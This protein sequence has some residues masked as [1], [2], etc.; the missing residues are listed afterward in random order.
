MGT[1][2]SPGTATG[3][4]AGCAGCTAT[5][6]RSFVGATGASGRASAAL[7]ASKAGKYNTAPEGSNEKE[8]GFTHRFGSG[9][10]GQEKAHSTHRLR[11]PSLLGVVLFIPLGVRT[12]SGYTLFTLRGGSGGGKSALG[13]LVAICHGG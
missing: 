2:R 8:D 10:A 5:A 9:T 12:H 13:P 1:A 4:A 7:S 3:G 6:C 11:P